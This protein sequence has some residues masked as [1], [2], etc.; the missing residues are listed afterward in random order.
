MAEPVGSWVA[1]PT[2][3]SE[4]EAINFEVFE[5]LVAFHAGNGSSALL[6]MGSC[7]EATLLTA[8]ERRRVI[9]IIAPFADGKIPV[10]FG[11]T[12][13]ST[14]ESIALTR[15]AE[16]MGADGVVLTVPPYVTPPQ[17]ACL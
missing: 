2:P 11:T 6:V 17:E 16:E 4:D 9:D 14:R 13:P 1:I 5:R 3:F 12:C 10:Y 8:E 15:Y 7:G